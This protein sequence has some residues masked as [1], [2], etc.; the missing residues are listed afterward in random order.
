MLAIMIGFKFFVVGLFLIAAFLCV[1][2]NP[3]RRR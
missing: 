1:T 3:N 2:D